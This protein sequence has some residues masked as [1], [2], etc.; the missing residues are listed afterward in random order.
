MRLFSP[1]G[2]KTRPTAD[3]IKES[4]FNILGNKVYA[5]NFLDLYAGSGAIGI[6]ALSRGATF[7]TFIE[8]SQSAVSVIRRNLERAKME[9]YARIIQK[10][11][12][13]AIRTMNQNIA[14]NLSQM[15]DIIFID[16]PYFR[17][18]IPKTLKAIA[19][20]DILEEEGLIIAE[21][22]KDEW[23]THFK[24]NDIIEGFEVIKHRSY[25]GTDLVFLTQ[26]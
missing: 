14:P 8:I 17:G 11:V 9:G 15:Y 3:F 24:G 5:S 21:L 13:K 23:K 12:Q 4:L 6:E 20:S 22:G 16:P 10:D 19:D 18:F 26:K 1:V 7:A 2:L 25:S